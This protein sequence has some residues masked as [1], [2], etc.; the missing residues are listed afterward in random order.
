MHKVLQSLQLSL[1]NIG[2]AHL[3]SHWNYDNVISPFTRMYY[4]TKGSAKVYHNGKEFSLKPG[5]MYLIP[6]YT[7]SRYKCDEYHEQ[8]YISFFEEIKNGLSIFNLKSFIYEIESTPPDLE[9]FKRLL[10]INPNRALIDDDPEVYDN[11]PTLLHFKRKNEKL[12]AAFFLE[13]RGFL[14]ILLSRFIEDTSDSTVRTNSGYNLSQVLNYI[15]ENLHRE[16]TIS[17]LASYCHL[18][19]D[20]F[21]RI[22]KD[23]FGMRPNIYMQSKRV[24]R[25]QLLLL[26]TN[27]SLQQ[28]AEKVGLENL[29]YFSRVFKKHAGKTPGNFRR[30]QMKV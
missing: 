28:I 17:E 8:Y 18:S 25:A 26:T 11:R 30:E 13:T 12:S 1:L 24:E 27:Y 23:K 16:L 9:Y 29:S 5:Y 22:F 3:D 6:S 14:N 19:T 10:E 7:Y 20:Y 21:S 2:Y 15:G 4:I